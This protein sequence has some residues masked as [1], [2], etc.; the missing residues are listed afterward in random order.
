MTYFCRHIGIIT[1]HPEKLITFYSE[2]VGF[3]LEETKNVPEDLMERIFGISSPAS[4]TK[5]KLA[6]VILEIFSLEEPLI[7]NRPLDVA[8]YNHWGLAVGDREAFVEKLKAKGVKVLDWK[9]EG[10]T[11]FFV[12]DPDGNLVEI[13]GVRKG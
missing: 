2:K 6:Q 12:A 9:R 1:A 8:G 11:I 3:E 7:Q 13:Y 5:L 10:R 4:L